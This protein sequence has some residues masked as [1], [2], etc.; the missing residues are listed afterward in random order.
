MAYHFHNGTYYDIA[1]L[2]FHPKVQDDVSPTADPFGNPNSAARMQG[3][4]LDIG[5][6]DELEFINGAITITDWIFAESA[7]DW[8]ALVNK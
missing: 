1:G 2:N 6:A 4:Y 3:G 5:D 7:D 8:T